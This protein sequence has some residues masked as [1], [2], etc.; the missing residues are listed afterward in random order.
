MVGRKAVYKSGHLKIAGD[1]AR[2][3]CTINMIATKLK[4][5]KSTLYNWMQANQ[6]LR[7]A[8]NEGRDYFDSRV[9]EGSLLKRVK[10]FTSKETKT[11]TVEG[12]DKTR[13]TVTK[14]K[15]APD[16]PAIIFW[17][18]NRQ[19]DRWRDKHDIE[20]RGGEGLEDRLRKAQARFLKQN[21]KPDPGEWE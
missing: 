15:I 5:K 6:D 18:K 20:V 12:S 1:A 10:G 11:V 4:I 13:I 16:T 7:D 14:K 17:L 9:A 3:G 8:I 21:K 19:G 2:D